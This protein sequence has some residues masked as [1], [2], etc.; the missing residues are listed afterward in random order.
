MKY[1]ITQSPMKLYG[2]KTADEKQGSFWRLDQEIMEK[3]P[4]YAYL[5]RR[6]CGGRVRFCTDAEE[7][8]VRMQVARTDE[9]INIPLS[10]SAGADAYAG[11]G[12]SARYLGYL[13]PDKHQKESA[14]AEK[15]FRKGPGMEVVVINL[16]RNEHL[17]SMEIE[18]PEGSRVCEAPKY[19]FSKPVIFDG[20]SITEGGC[21][22]RG[23]NAYTSLVCRWLDA[24][25]R[26]FGF[27]GSA[28]GETVFA[29]YIAA[30]EDMGAFVY[31]YDH[32]APTPEHLEA[33][34]ERFFRIIRKAHPALP[35]LMMSRP[36][37]DDDPADA[38][39]RRE[40]IRRTYERA[41]SE[42]DRRVWFLDGHS[43]F[44]AEGRAECT[45]DRV[46]PNALGFMRMAQRVYPVLREMLLA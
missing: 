7:F 21:A 14:L 16:P 44:G 18:F 11:I 24:D 40:I 26:N 10:G 30:Q 15:V 38:L 34:H 41:I 25:Y 19:R 12:V 29:E 32:N 5:G 4:Q 28:K 23:G 20:A 22:A 8:L 35:V 1:G 45:V 39:V 3:M 46:H 31:D 42:G 37:T 17:H 36:N 6:C 2:L 43:L 9:D 27:S 33:T 13:S